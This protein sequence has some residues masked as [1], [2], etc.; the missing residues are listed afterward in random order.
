MM[1]VRSCAVLLWVSMLLGAPAHA[2]DVVVNEYNAVREDLFL[3]GDKSD[4]YL[5]RRLEN[6]GDWFELVVITDH[7][8]MRLWDFVVVN[9]AGVM[10]ME[11]TFVLTLTNDPVW[12]DLRAGT[13]ITVSEDIPNNVEAYQPETGSWWFNVRADLNAL[14]TF[15]TALNFKTSND[16]TQILVRDKFDVPVFG[17][18]GEGVTPAAGVGNN[19]VWKLEETPTS[20]T[21]PNSTYNDG[22][23][24]T[25]GAANVWSSGLQSQDLSTLRSII[26]YT[27]LTDVIVNEVTSHTDLPEID[28]VELYNTTGAPIDIGDWFLSDGTNDLQ[29]FQIPS[30]TIIPAN[31]YLVFT[32]TVLG[33][34]FNAEFG[35]E[36]FLSVDDGIGGMTG[37]RAW[38]E[39]GGVENGVTFGRSPNGFGNVYR[40]KANTLGSANAAPD[41]GPIVINELMYNPPVPMSG[42]LTVNELEY[43]E[44][45]NTS[46]SAV[47]LTV[48]YGAEGVF[49]WKLGFGVEFNFATGTSMPPR[50]HLIVVPLDPVL[51]AAKVAD[52]R[53]HYGLDG[54]IPI[55]GPYSGGLNDMTER[56]D[57]IRPD[58]ASFGVA[59]DVIRDSVTYWDFR[60]WPTAPDGNGPSLERRNPSAPGDLFTNWGAG[61]NGGTPGVQNSLSVRPVPSLQPAMLVVLVVV[62]S[63][64]GLVARRFAP[65]EARSR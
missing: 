13:V 48:D 8:D 45:F 44:L 55:V 31:G 22:A 49:P 1:L 26:P 37:E 41:I 62:L 59:P 28:A 7:L 25:Y 16:R 39:F 30:S 38:F 34:A 51:Q 53:S 20:G 14:G 40:M 63:V 58:N 17:P 21:T 6:G 3:Q 5:G 57:L 56:I 36:V 32:E 35:D 24:S 12:F 42:T 50:S 27:E 2:A 9:N 18:A 15:I 64:L 60:D 4:P 65:A 19:E 29:Q 11:E 10:G 46:S 43:I 61:P 33:F 47:D 54:S 52:F 23:S